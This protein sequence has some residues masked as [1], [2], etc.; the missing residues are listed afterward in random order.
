MVP[1]RPAVDSVDDGYRVSAPVASY[2]A[3]AW[4]LHDMH[5]NVSEWTVNTDADQAILRGGSWYDRPKEADATTRYAYPPWRKVF[6]VGFRIVM[7]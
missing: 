7:E 6:N 3:N 4:G 1:F 5:G 2:Q